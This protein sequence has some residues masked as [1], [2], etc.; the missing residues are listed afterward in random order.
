MATS[1]LNR[2]AGLQSLYAMLID[3]WMALSLE[4][5]EAEVIRQT[6]DI[7]RRLYA[8]GRRPDQVSWSLVA[9]LRAT[10]IFYLCRRSA[11]GVAAVPTEDHDISQI[12]DRIQDIVSRNDRGLPWEFQSTR[13]REYYIARKRGEIEERR[14]LKVE[15][16]TDKVFCK[17]FCR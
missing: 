15:E 16:M 11:P 4:D 5:A 1:T 8:Y 6:E 3:S 17:L 14:E 10:K 7:F 2:L 13:Y 12:V 9:E